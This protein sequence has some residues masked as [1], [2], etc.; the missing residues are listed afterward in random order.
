LTYV[1]SYDVTSNICTPYPEVANK[2]REAVDDVG[3]FRDAA[4][5][6]LRKARSARAAVVG[7]GT[8]CSRHVIQCTLNLRLLN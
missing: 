7:P 1:A 4:S 3:E 5:P 6:E 2:I 8:H